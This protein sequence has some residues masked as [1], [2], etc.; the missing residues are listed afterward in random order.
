MPVFKARHKIVRVA[1]HS[2]ASLL[3]GSHHPLEP[4]VQRVVQVDVGQHRR[5]YS[6]LRCSRLRMDYLPILFQY[7]RPQPL[8]DQVQCRSIS[9]P[10][11]QHPFQPFPLDV[12]EESFDVRFYHEVVSAELQLLAQVLDRIVCAHAWP[13]A[14]AAR[15]KVHFVYRQ[16]ELRHRYLQQLVLQYWDA[17]GAEFPVA[18]GYVFA[19]HQPRSIR[20]ALEPPFQ[21][22]QVAFQVSFIFLK[23]HPVHATGCVFPQAVEALA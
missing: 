14:I 5:D 10:L 11:F 3:L 19:S 21:V 17:Q 1:D 8:A 9:N 2:A 22:C 13:V 16:Q 20:L 18:L 12:V 23:T 6:A 15:Q 4:Q 7:P